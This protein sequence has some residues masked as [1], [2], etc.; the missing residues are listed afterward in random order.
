MLF[1]RPPNNHS[2]AESLKGADWSIC[3][4]QDE[5]RVAESAGGYRVELHRAGKPYVIFMD[6]LTQD[7]AERAVHSLTALWTKISARRPSVAV[8]PWSASQV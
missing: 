2:G 6:G 1:R 5:F 8:T 7:S 3:M 4:P